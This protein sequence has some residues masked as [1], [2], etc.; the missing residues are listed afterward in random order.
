MPE[1]L[2]SV[3]TYG[4]VMSTAAVFIALGGV[5]YAV[6]AGSIDSREIK[7]NTIVSKDV[8]DGGLLKADFASGQLPAGEQGPPGDQG[9]RGATGP[10]GATGLQGSAGT[11]GATGPRGTTGLRGATGDRG[12][13]GFST[14]FVQT[15]SVSTP[16]ATT[17]IDSVS[18]PA[19]FPR[20]TGGGYEINPGFEAF[21]QVI[22]SRPTGGG[23]GWA[24]RMSNHGNSLNLPYTIWVICV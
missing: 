4:N 5:S 11:R 15:G 18:C 21:A 1:K 9:P 14:T 10:Q 19:G 6:A 2:R 23:G 20:A 22:D 7:D 24:V 17:E 8:R 3:L 13:A 16:P 12:P